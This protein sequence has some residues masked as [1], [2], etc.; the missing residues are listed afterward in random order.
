LGER[1]WFLALH[2]KE[3]TI[4]LAQGNLPGAD[5]EIEIALDEAERRNRVTGVI[6]TLLVRGMIRLEMGDI[7]GAERAAN[8]MRIEIEG[9]LNPKLMRQW[10]RLAGHIDLARNDVGQ[11]V[12]RFEQAVALLPYQHERN[13]DGHAEY[14]SSLAYAYYLSGD[15]AKAQEWNENI[16]ALT[17]GREAYGEIYAKSYF[18][19]GKIYEQRGMNAEAIRSYRTFLDLWR[20]AD[21][22]APDIEE[23][24]RA[25]ADLLG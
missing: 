3:A 19:L 13:G 12:K 6:S 2:F 1:R 10:H 14:F 17:S 11:A 5:A 18:M 23:A 24:K 9:W 16:L 25:L 8:E 15:M 4:L 21:S 7:R 20:E 22:T